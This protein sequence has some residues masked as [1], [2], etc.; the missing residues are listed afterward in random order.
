MRAP[1]ENGAH[2]RGTVARDEVYTVLAEITAKPGKEAPLRAATAPLVALALAE[3]NVLEFVL[4]EDREQQGHFILYEVYAS[5]AAF[6]EHVAKPHVRAWF[7]RLPE[8]VAGE[9]RVVRLAVVDTGAAS[10]GGVT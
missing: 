2:M 6:D 7:A 4:C 5:R 8:L 9:T 1:V 3:Q 10:S